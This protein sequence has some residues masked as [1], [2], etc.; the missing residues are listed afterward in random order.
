MS[1]GPPSV[2]AHSF[3][4]HIE[5]GMVCKSEKKNNREERRR[6][7]EIQRAKERGMAIKKNKRERQRQRQKDIEDSDNKIG[8]RERSRVI[9]VLKTERRCDN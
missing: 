6:K 1:S 2:P 5:K 7:E 4:V 8:N 9:S 3:V